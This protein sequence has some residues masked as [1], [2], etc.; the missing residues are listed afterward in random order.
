VT[1][2]VV[3][4]T[5]AYYEASWVMMIGPGVMILVV[6]GAGAALLEKFLRDASKKSV[7]PRPPGRANA[8]MPEPYRLSP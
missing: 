4:T 5:M 1:I 3:W 2:V 8:V 6:L 7:P